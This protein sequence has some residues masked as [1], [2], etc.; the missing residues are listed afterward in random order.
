MMLT[1]G[2]AL[3]N[4]E[5][6]KNVLVDF[7]LQ[8]RDVQQGLFFND[9]EHLISLLE[10]ISG[11][12]SQKIPLYRTWV[13]KIGEKE[14]RLSVPHPI[15]KE[16]I[17]DYLLPL[18]K[19]IDVHENCHGAEKG[20]SVKAS[21]ETHLPCQSVLAFDL[22]SAYE[23]VPCEWISDF[24]RNLASKN[25]FEDAKWDIAKFFTALSVVSYGV[26]KGI[27]K[28]GLP[29]GSSLSTGLF[30]RLLKPLDYVLSKKSKERGFAYSRW[31][32]DLTISS[33]NQEGIGKFL[34]AVGI[35]MTH[36]PVS[37]KKVFFQQQAEDK[38]I[39]LLGY[40]IYE[41]KILKNSKED[42]E[43]NKTPAIDFYD[44]FAST[45]NSYES[46]N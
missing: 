21:L 18:V 3:E 8:N 1:I 45:K 25:G 26:K 2:E 40:K 24:Y 31:V 10:S 7:L 29:Q 38:P 41:R 34:G 17:D 30:N 4:Y 13:Q 5:K 12:R 36:F 44:W 43:A 14:R 27:S 15:L 46:W 6:K 39:Y 16:F 37:D 32:D 19:S 42:R 20:W 11:L 33:Q 23:N 35:T 9:K 28:D 22:K